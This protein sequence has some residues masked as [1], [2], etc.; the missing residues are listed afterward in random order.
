MGVVVRFRGSFTFVRG[1]VVP[2]LLLSAFP[3]LRPVTLLRK[4]GLLQ[5]RGGS[6]IAGCAFFLYDGGVLV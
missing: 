4:E 3:G 1:V 6:A 5:H 2:T